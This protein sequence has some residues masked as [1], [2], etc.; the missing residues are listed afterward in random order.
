MLGDVLRRDFDGA[1]GED[2]FDKQMLP[3]IMQAC[4]L[5]AWLFILFWS[6]LALGWG[7]RETTSS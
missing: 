4:C 5:A 7:Q 3:K 6:R 2:K 1:T